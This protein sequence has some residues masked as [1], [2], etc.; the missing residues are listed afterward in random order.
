[1]EE[2]DIDNEDDDDLENDQLYNEETALHF[3]SANRQQSISLADLIFEKLREKE[4]LQQQLQQEQEGGEGNQALTNMQPSQQ[5][6]PSKVIEVYESV[7]KLLQF[8]RSGKIPKALKML[9]HLKAWERI[10]WI[11]R[12]DLWSP[13]A[14]YVVTR[15]FASNLHVKLAERFCH[16]VVLE[17]C[18][19]DIQQHGKLNYHLYMALKKSCFKPAAFFKGILLPLLQS[20]TCTLREALII[21]SVLLKVSIPAVHTAAALL[22]LIE[23]PYNGAISV[24]MK[25]TFQK[26]YAFP[27]RVIGSLYTYFIQFSHET[28]P[29]PLIWHVSLL[30]FI[31]RYKFELLEEQVEG[32]HSLLRIKGHVEIGQEIRRELAS[33]RN[34]TLL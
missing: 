33:R 20:G 19:D 28:R 23:I 11:T 4:E 3:L 9:P 5:A 24:I 30:W 27:M 10:L 34:T 17:K 25:I 26:K 14:T 21:G 22:R 8:Y 2:D 31:R 13:A 18:R 32:I 29:L 1:V 12:P 16:I 7:G 6:I 15:I